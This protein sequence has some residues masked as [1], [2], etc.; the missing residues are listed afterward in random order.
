MNP[1]MNSHRLN[2]IK[3]SLNAVKVRLS[4]SAV[5]A[6]AVSLLYA[7]ALMVCPRA[8]PEL[9]KHIF[10]SGRFFP[11]LTVLLVAANEILF[12]LISRRRAQGPGLLTPGYIAILTIGVVLQFRLL[13]YT[14]HAQAQLSHLSLSLS[15]LQ[16]SSGILDGISSEDLLVYT[17]LALVSGIVLP[18]L[19]VRLTQNYMP[20]TSSADHDAKVRNA[21]AGQ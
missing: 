20:N 13:V 8:F 1:V 16:A 10:E 18:F 7:V 5:L 9:L 12:V 17:H 3:V 14:A 11:A 21:V 2:A 19:L 4:D 6:G 15:S